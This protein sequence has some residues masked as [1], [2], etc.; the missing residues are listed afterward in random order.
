MVLV[1]V[2]LVAWIMTA[3]N[4]VVVVKALKWFTMVV[5]RG[6]RGANGDGSILIC[7]SPLSAPL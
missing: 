2:V 4:L 3:E 1:A 6:I 7:C 5:I